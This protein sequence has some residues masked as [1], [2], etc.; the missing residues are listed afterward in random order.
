MRTLL[1]CSNETTPP[2]A[3]VPELPSRKHM[4]PMSSTSAPTQTVL[5]VEDNLDNLALVRQ[6]LA[7]RDGVTVISASN[8]SEGI[9]KARTLHPDLIL[10]DINM[11]VMGGMEALEILLAEPSTRDIPVIALSSNAYPKQIAQGLDAGFHGY[12]T[13]PFRFDEFLAAVDAGLHHV[14]VL[15]SEHKD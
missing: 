5:Y 10:M 12:L 14:S 8:G 3:A 13:K 4:M 1:Y 2:S 11:P 7:R 15:Q 6:I 9:E